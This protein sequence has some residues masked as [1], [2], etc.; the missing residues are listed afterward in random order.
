MDRSP[1]SLRPVVAVVAAA[2]LGGVAA[3]GG[4]ALLGDLGG[5]TVVREFVQSPTP[6]EPAAFATKGERLTIN[7]IYNR[8]APGVVQI[9]ATSSR[10]VQPDPF[11]GNPFGQPERQTQQALGSGFVLDK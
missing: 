8:N 5:K 1:S 7:Q 9:T 4:A 2:V 3:L 11:F 10:Q 6:G